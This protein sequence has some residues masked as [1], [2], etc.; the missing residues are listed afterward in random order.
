MQAIKP[1][2]LSAIRCVICHEFALPISHHTRMSRLSNKA[3]STS[4][5]FIPYPL[6]RL[7]QHIQITVLGSV[8][9]EIDPDG[10]AS[11][12]ACG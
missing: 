8:I 2:L 12:D 4:H 9:G 6:N 7:N 5:K 1:S 11:V 3:L 10:E